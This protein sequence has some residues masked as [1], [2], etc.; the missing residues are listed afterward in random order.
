MCG[1]TISYCAVNAHHQNGKAHQTRASY[2]CHNSR[3][4]RCSRFCNCLSFRVN[5][6]DLTSQIT[7]FMLTMA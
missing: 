2:V 3:V 4:I 7:H 5:R 1:Q 6:T